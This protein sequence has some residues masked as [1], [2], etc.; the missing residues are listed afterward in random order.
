MAPHCRSRPLM[1]LLGFKW[2]FD[3]PGVPGMRTEGLMARQRQRRRWRSRRAG[4]SAGLLF[5]AGVSFGAGVRDEEE[6]PRPRPTLETSSA[7]LIQGAIDRMPVA[8]FVSQAVAPDERVTIASLERTG[9]SDV[10]PGQVF[11]DALIEA[12]SEAQITVL[13][14][15]I[16][17]TS[18]MAAETSEGY[19]REYLRALPQ[20]PSI[21]LLDRLV[22]FQSQLLESRMGEFGPVTA[23]VGLEESVI[24]QWPGES[25]GPFDYAGFISYYTVLRDDLRSLFEERENPVA[26]DVLLS[27]RVLEVGIRTRRETIRTQRET[28]TGSQVQITVTRDALARIAA[29]IVDA[30]TGEIRAATTFTGQKTHVAT[31]SQQG[32]ETTAALNRAVSEYITA[33]NDFHYTFYGAE[34]P[35]VPVA[36]SGSVPGPSV[37][38][39][40]ESTDSPPNPLEGAIIGI[41]VATAVGL[42]IL[43]A[44][45]LAPV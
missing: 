2:A 16:H 37:D 18:R 15:D 27:Y 29:R 9:T 23:S 31:F 8:D 45:T 20:P 33:A 13:D 25:T 3:D 11:D 24:F 7:V 38:E 28:G 36:E 4:V 5:V 10:P 35:Y 39:S 40:F 32:L 42:I 26:A 12:L 43:L 22:P 1:G 41:G 30:S 6:P 17:T 19:R 44:V 34:L 21:G 14:R